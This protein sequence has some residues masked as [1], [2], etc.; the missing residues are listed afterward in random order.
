[1]AEKSVLRYYFDK[2]VAKPKVSELMYNK[3]YN[4]HVL[5]M[6]TSIVGIQAFHCM[7][8]PQ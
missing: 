2:L 7:T 5:E 3:D 4:I 1:M 6:P 8:T